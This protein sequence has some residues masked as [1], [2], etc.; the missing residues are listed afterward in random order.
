V[1]VEKRDHAECLTDFVHPEWAIYVFGPEDG[2][3]PK[4]VR[5]ACHRFVWIP[6][7]QCLNLA[8]AVNV[9]LCHRRMSRQLAGRERR[10]VLAD[11]KGYVP[12][13][14]DVGGWDGR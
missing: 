10:I 2:S 9:V 5:H 3:L 11:T 1:G 8:A 12:A 7:E 4:A 14:I 13:P 6:S